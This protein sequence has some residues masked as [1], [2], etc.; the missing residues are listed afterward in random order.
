MLHPTASRAESEI[1]SQTSDVRSDKP[2]GVLHSAH[3]GASGFLLATSDAGAACGRFSFAH[4]TAAAFDVFHR[5]QVT[6]YG[7][8]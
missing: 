4:N 2:E 1:R 6:N 8:F 7:L 3:P 5:L